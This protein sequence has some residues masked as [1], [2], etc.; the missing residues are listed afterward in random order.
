MPAPD[1]DQVAEIIHAHTTA[2]AHLLAGL[3]LLLAAVAIALTIADV[4]RD[5]FDGLGLIALLCCLAAAG[6]ARAAQRRR[7]EL[8]RQAER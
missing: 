8:D 5:R 6:I 2:E 1:R 4:V 3:Q 7:D